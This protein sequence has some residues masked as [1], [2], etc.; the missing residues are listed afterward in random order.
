MFEEFLK[1]VQVEAPPGKKDFQA[2]VC[3]YQKGDIITRAGSIEN[4]IYLIREGGVKVSY[5][6]EIKE[7]ILDFWFE[8]DFFSSYVSF[9]QRNP[10]LTQIQALT[11]TRVERISWDQLQQL[12]QESKIGNEIGRKMAEALYIHK[13]M[14][15]I[16]LISQ[17]AE[18]RYRT[19]LEKSKNM[20]QEVS[21]KEMAS[22]LGI[23]AESLSRIRRKILS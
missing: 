16:S 4:H 3:H 6:K 17:T 5:F 1:K 7:Y 18:E 20:V 10:S 2:E 8:G 9:I 19:L 12:Y 15:E 14:K 21:V 11:T 13:T 22:Y 23:E